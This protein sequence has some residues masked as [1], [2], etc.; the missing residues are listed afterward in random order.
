MAG[1]NEMDTKA[2]RLVIFF[3]SLTVFIVTTIMTF[4][5]RAVLST[6]DD[7]LIGMSRGTVIW[8]YYLNIILAIISFFVFFVNLFKILFG[9]KS[10]GGLIPKFLFEENE[11]LF[12]YPETQAGSAPA[13]APAPDPLASVRGGAQPAG[14]PAPAPT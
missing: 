13:A 3:L 11:G 8:F 7:T 1:F 6:E 14:A 10:I 4:K 12:E 9:K 2:Y 5:Y